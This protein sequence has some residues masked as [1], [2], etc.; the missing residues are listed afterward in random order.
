MAIWMQI[1]HRP[2][3]KMVIMAA[4]VDKLPFSLKAMVLWRKMAIAL[5]YNIPVHPAQHHVRPMSENCSPHLLTKHDRN[6]KIMN[7]K[8]NKRKTNSKQTNY[9]NEWN[10]NNKLTN[11][12]KISKFNDQIEYWHEEPNQFQLKSYEFLFISSKSAWNLQHFVF[13]PYFS[14]DSMCSLPKKTR[15][16]SEFT[17]ISCENAINSDL[18]GQRLT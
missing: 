7:K 12:L 18:V 17:L 14:F 2:R 15:T 3:T 4:T 16:K 11:Q 9:Q 5:W 6:E 1:H 10:Q 13:A 8:I